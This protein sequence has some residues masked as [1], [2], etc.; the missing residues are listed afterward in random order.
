MFSIDTTKFDKK[1]FFIN[2]SSMSNIPSSTS[3]AMSSS[4]YLQL[5]SIP[6][7]RIKISPIIIT[8]TSSTTPTS[9]IKTPEITLTSG[10]I[11]TP[12][13]KVMNR[14]NENE[15]LIINKKTKKIEIGK[16]D[17][18]ENNNIHIGNKS[19]FID[20]DSLNEILNE[21]DK[22]P[23]KKL[24]LI[25]DAEVY[26]YLTP[27]ELLLE[28]S[29][30][31]VYDINDFI[32]RNGLYIYRMTEIGD[33]IKLILTDKNEY[34]KNYEKTYYIG[35]NY[36]SKDECLNDV[37]LQN[38]IDNGTN[39]NIYGACI[40]DDCKYILRITEFEKDYESRFN[41]FEEEVEIMN[42][43]YELGVG[44]KLIRSWKCEVTRKNRILDI[45]LMLIEKYDTDLKK[46]SKNITNNDFEKI[47]KMIEKIH[48]NG[49]IH[50]DLHPKNIILKINKDGIEDIKIIDYST[51]FHVTSP[52]KN[53]TIDEL[54]NFRKNKFTFNDLNAKTFEEK[55]KT[56]Q[57]YDKYLWMISSKSI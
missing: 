55:I 30:N 31:D 8:P 18:K 1:R 50:G 21:N 4:T 44:P 33:K 46:Y 57:I 22:N 23:N 16:K 54:I 49:Y 35:T 56:L 38:N 13:S 9:S 20:L 15:V 3:S 27:I 45:G 14:I 26:E 29:N 40:K 32:A 37:I 10:P 5:S 51:T 47:N 2:S 34:P 11:S 42:K 12:S 36:V 41:N 6:T 52:F 17:K 39:S 48:D 28:I 43:M 24:Y 25:Y 7:S 19:F 53:K